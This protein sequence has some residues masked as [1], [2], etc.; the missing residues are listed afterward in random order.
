[1][2]KTMRT[3]IRAIVFRKIDHEWMGVWLQQIGPRPLFNL[4]LQRLRFD[5]PLIKY[6]RLD[7]G[8]FCWRM[9]L[10]QLDELKGF[11][12]RNGLNLLEEIGG[13]LYER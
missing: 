4:V 6:E 13:I 11:C 2:Q 9:G 1:M 12:R 3:A 8:Q 7:D 10:S 5:F